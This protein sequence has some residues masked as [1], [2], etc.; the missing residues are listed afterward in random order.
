[1]IVINYQN[2]NMAKMSENE[3]GLSLYEIGG[4][5]NEMDEEN[6]D[7]LVRFYSKAFDVL[8]KKG[9]MPKKVFVCGCGSGADVL[10]VNLTWPDAEICAVDVQDKPREKVFL[11]CGK[12]LQFKE[13]SILA[14][15]EARVGIDDKFDLTVVFD[16][17]SDNIHSFSLP[18]ELAKISFNNGY[19]Y[20][21]WQTAMG[22]L[23]QKRMRIYF[24]TVDLPDYYKERDFKLWKRK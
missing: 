9:H 19:V 8:R 20:N 1:M 7:F 6:F 21:Y 4:V 22:P 12:K 2:T 10:A 16:I 5:T 11:Q 3:T 18:Y 24:E 15:I 13:S 14:E 23:N 17:A